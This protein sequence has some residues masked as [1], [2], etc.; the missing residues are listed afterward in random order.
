MNTTRSDHHVPP[1]LPPK[2]S[3]LLRSIPAGGVLEMF[4]LE[5]SG[6]KQSWV[7]GVPGWVSEA[8]KN[9]HPLA[10]KEGSF[11]RDINNRKME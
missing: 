8:S 6:V 1:Q 4:L 10:A 3:P 2:S 5:C 9:L 11:R 7:R